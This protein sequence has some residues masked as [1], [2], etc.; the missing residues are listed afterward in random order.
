MTEILMQ[1]KREFI[2][3]IKSVSKSWQAALFVGFS[4]EHAELSVLNLS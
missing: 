3:S 4:S 2:N 1:I